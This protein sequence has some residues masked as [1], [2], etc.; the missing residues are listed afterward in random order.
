MDLSHRR[1]RTMNHQHRIH[2]PHGHRKHQLPFHPR[3]VTHL[4]FPP[5]DC[6][7]YLHL[8]FRPLHVRNDQFYR[9]TRYTYQCSCNNMN[10]GIPLL[11]GGRRRMRFEFVMK[12]GTFRRRKCFCRWTSGM[13]SAK[14]D[15]FAHP[16]QIWHFTML[17][18]G[19]S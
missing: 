14:T 16:T 1:T 2:T 18:F 17:S 19:R 15:P 8:W 10:V 11:H 9:G 12:L 5:V 4:L 6:W 13:P 7:L 3:N